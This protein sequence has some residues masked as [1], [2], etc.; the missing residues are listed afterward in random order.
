MPLALQLNDK[1]GAWSGRWVSTTV[2]LIENPTDNSLPPNIRGKANYLDH[3]TG[4]LI[5]HAQQNISNS[6]KTQSGFKHLIVYKAKSKSLYDKTNIID[7]VPHYLEDGVTIDYYE[8]TYIGSWSN[9]NIA[10]T[11]SSKRFNNGF[12]TWNNNLDLYGSGE[13]TS[14]TA[15]EPF[16]TLRPTKGAINCLFEFSSYVKKEGVN[17]GQLLFT[18]FQL[19]IN[20]MTPEEDREYYVRMA[21]GL[22]DILLYGHSNVD[23]REEVEK[24]SGG[25]DW[26]VD[27]DG[28]KNPNVLIKWTPQE[29]IQEYLDNG[30]YVHMS[31][32]VIGFTTGEPT[33]FSEFNIIDGSDGSITTTY[34]DL[35]L[36]AQKGDDVPDFIQKVT[37]VFAKNNIELRF[38]LNY[39]KENDSGEIVRENTSI[40]FARFSY[41]AERISKGILAGQADD[42]STVEWGGS[43]DYNNDSADT[44]SDNYNSSSDEGTNDGSDFGDVTDS[45]VSIYQLTSAQLE[46]F[47]NYLWGDNFIQDIKLVNNNP[48]E[49]IV[50]IKRF[51]ISAG[52]SGSGSVVVGNVDTGVSASI[53]A[54][55][56]TITKTISVPSH[57]KNFLD[58]APY[59]SVSLY[60]PFVGVIEVDTNRVIGK[61]IQIKCSIDYVQGTCV[62]YV[63]DYKHCLLGQYSGMCAID[64]PVTGNN[65]AQVTSAYVMGGGSTVASLATG[66]VLSATMTALSTAQVKHHYETKGS[67]NSACL[68]G[69]NQNIVLVVDYPMYQNLSKFNHTKGRKCNLSKKISELKGYTVFNDSIDLSG[70]GG[71]KEEIEELKNLMIGGVY[72]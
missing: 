24:S 38:S 21:K 48:M 17:Y 4:Y 25:C 63:Y 18:D 68:G 27:L 66:N 14:Y 49:N 8:F 33:N 3:A 53:C 22:S 2:G 37:N 34:N 71:T 70:I 65:N 13:L 30:Y 23:W 52:I 47:K 56:K 31:V 36:K 55:T 39:Q 20:N 59:T 9:G 58:Y 64:S 61:S 60:L 57:Y 50:G 26:K 15:E 35:L 69:A 40:C 5:V 42:G 12:T 54:R 67:F 6:N 28:T 45:A 19:D 51:P 11:S 72:L 46:Q 1:A 7:S 32:G 16:G 41:A 62:Y 43:E 10:D 44:S 29:G